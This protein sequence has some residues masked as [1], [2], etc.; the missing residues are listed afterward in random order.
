[1]N[2]AAEMSAEARLA[3]LTE[4]DEM[5]NVICR[6]A[7]MCKPCDPDETTGW[8]D[9]AMKL[10]NVIQ[11][12]KNELQM[13]A[14]EGVQERTEADQTQGSIC[15]SWHEIVVGNKLDEK[16]TE[17]RCYAVPETPHCNCGGDR[18]RCDYYG[19]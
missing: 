4:L 8:M 5:Q 10:V 19:G 13:G 11:D 17:H 7:V 12:R 16:I 3:V 2:K 1:M 15:P 9:F 14:P 6:T 18:E